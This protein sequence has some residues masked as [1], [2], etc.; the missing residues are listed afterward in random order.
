MPIRRRREKSFLRGS[1]AYLSGPMDFV[2]SRAS[3]MKHGW[4][5]RVSEVLRSLG[6]SVFD[7]WHKPE[8]R[9]LYDYGREGIDTAARRET[10]TFEPGPRGSEG[11]ARCSGKFWETMH[12]DLRMVDKSDFVVAYC[13]TNIYSVGTPHEVVLCRQQRK[14]VLFVSPP[15]TFPS[16]DGL[17]RHLADD[18]VGSR[19]LESL[20]QE[21]PI[22]ENPKGI[23]SLWYMPLVGPDNFFDGF[24]FAPFRKE[25]GWEG[26]IA[27][28]RYEAGYRVESPLLPHLLRLA[29]AGPRRWDNRTKRYRRDDSW[30]LWDGDSAQRP[31]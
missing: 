5:N 11:R 8:V 29:K 16:L 14:P 27:I 7:P 10:W 28:D 18:R 31:G 19:M 4:R 30:L 26:E 2:A 17:R 25:F 15:V 23:P 20:A 22:K 3:E 13:P 9:G 6:V 12:V 1:T 21:V 24:G